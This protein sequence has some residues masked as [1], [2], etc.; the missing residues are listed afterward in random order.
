[1]TFQLRGVR[2]PSRL[3]PR[4]ARSILLPPPLQR[5]RLFPALIMRPTWFFGL[6]LRLPSWWPRFAPLWRCAKT[7]SKRQSG[8]CR[9]SMLNFRQAYEQKPVCGKTVLRIAE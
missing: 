9:L 4:L 6:I 3:E 2:Y 7:D 1:M 8:G 5:R